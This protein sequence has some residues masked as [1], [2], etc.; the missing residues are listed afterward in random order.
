MG[1]ALKKSHIREAAFLLIF[2]KMFRDDSCEE[3][4]ESAKEAD[5]YEFDDEVCR[6]FKAVAEKS[7]E[8]DGI[9]SE[10]SEKRKVGRIGKVSLAI[11]RLAVY[12]AMYEE[13][14]PCNVAISE[15]VSLAEKYAFPNDKQFIN[16]ILGSFSRSGRV[17]EKQAEENK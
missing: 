9:I 2:E 11:L 13:C 1:K 14:V 6:I 5:E 16:G 15:A 12:E 3:I 17:P 8:L 10:Y 4:I 7:E